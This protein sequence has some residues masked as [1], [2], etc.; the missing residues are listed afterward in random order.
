MTTALAGFG[1]FENIYT[2]T[3][4]ITVDNFSLILSSGN[5]LDKLQILTDLSFRLVMLPLN[6]WFSVYA[7]FLADFIPVPSW[8]S[9]LQKLIMLIISGLSGTLWYLNLTQVQHP[10]INLLQSVLPRALT[11]PAFFW[12]EFITDPSTFSFIG[13]VC[14]V[15]SSCVFTFLFLTQLP[16]PDNGFF[17]E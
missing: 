16:S 13:N 5:E 3:Q 12:D 9:I 17:L 10:G 15:I 1:I 2:L 11:D 6:L 4:T 14:S 8:L 7:F